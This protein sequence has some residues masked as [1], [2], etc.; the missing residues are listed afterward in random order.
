MPLFLLALVFLLS[1]AGVSQ[2]TPAEQ[3]STPEQIFAREF[4]EEM[5]PVQGFNVIKAD[6]DNDGVED[7][8]MVVTGDNPMGRAAGMNYKVVDPSNDYFGYGNPKV[9]ASF[10]TDPVNKYILVIFSWRAE[11]PKA[12]FV[13]VNASFKKLTLG[14]VALRKKKTA[15]SMTAEESAGLAATIFWDGKKWRWA[16]LG[17]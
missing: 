15:A 8:A 13:I 14:S 11:T 9:T 10:N 3:T 12:K 16:P 17:M 5:K 4:G 6:F 2:E 1:A 7:A